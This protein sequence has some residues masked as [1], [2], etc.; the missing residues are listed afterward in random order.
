LG[1]ELGEVREGVY[2]NFIE[3]A[4]NCIDGGIYDP[5]HPQADVHGL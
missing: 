2:G 3:H 5:S 1:K 4:F